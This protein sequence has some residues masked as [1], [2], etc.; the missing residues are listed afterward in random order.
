M[1]DFLTWL[2]YAPA[3]IELAASIFVVCLFALPLCVALKFE[4]IL[5]ILCTVGLISVLYF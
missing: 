5:M 1:L 2:Y 4:D 3:Y